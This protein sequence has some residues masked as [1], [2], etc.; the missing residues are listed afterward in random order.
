MNEV[1]DFVDG[2]DVGIFR[3]VQRVR[4]VLLLGVKGLMMVGRVMPRRQR[5]SK[6]LLLG[7]G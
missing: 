6:A 1:D 2:V 4:Y 3:V 5:M 7:G